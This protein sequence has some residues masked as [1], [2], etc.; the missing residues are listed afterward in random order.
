MADSKLC[1][2]HN[3][4][5]RRQNII[6]KLITKSA[7]APDENCRISIKRGPVS[8]ETTLKELEED[9]EGKPEWKLVKDVFVI[10]DVD[11]VVIVFV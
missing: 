1:L 9:Y 7:S 10:V 3:E 11:V 2:G 6:A 8:V 5:A 4:R